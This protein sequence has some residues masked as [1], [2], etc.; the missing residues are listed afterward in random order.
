MSETDS[1]KTVNIASKVPGCKDNE[2]DRQGVRIN[3]SSSGRQVI[4]ESERI[5]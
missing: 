3:S 1:A 2:D 5:S 4:P